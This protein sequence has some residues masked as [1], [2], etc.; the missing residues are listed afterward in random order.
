MSD[1]TTERSQSAVPNLPGSGPASGNSN[2][3]NTNSFTN[4][5]TDSFAQALFEASKP[6]TPAKAAPDAAGRDATASTTPTPEGVPEREGSSV[7]PPQAEG[8]AKPED[9]SALTPQERERREEQ[10]F[11]DRYFAEK[12]QRET[13]EAERIREKAEQEAYSEQQRMA[14]MDQVEQQAVQ[15][16][17]A[18][19][20]PSE[21][22][23]R[24]LYA[25][26]NAARADGD[27][28]MANYLYQTRLILTNSINDQYGS[29]NQQTNMYRQQV[30]RERMT[31]QEKQL[32]RTLEKSGLTLEELKTANPK[33]NTS[34]PFEVIEAVSK[35]AAT[36]QEARFKA[37]IEKHKLEA[38]EAK[39][40]WRT[41]SPASVPDRRP[42][43]KG[44]TSGNRN[45]PGSATADL[46]E[47]LFG[48]RKR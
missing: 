40:K 30:T 14:Q 2:S 44:A 5:K 15:Q 37:D 12:T 48:S 19:M 17:K 39:E 36:K 8:A 6:R 47:G 28:E 31:A 21:A 13:L 38:K 22:H 43:G 1:T 16:F 20:E 25:R 34:N 18:R 24:D 9:E 29:F 10:S 33:L 11:K 42:T 41:D 23:C 45:G 27:D 46:T 26:E 4:P 35:V 3:T 32:G 7:E